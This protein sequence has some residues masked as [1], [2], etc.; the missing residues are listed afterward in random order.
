MFFFVIGEYMENIIIESNIF[1]KHN[2]VTLIYLP[3]VQ[4][5]FH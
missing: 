3:V 2:I 4:I 1:L 5:N